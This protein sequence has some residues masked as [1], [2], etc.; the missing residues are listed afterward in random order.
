MRNYLRDYVLV[1]GD[2]RSR[3]PY[4]AALMVLSA[5]L[6]F[7]GL[8]LIA[9]MIAALFGGRTNPVESWWPGAAIAAP[10][11]FFALGSAVFLA[12]LAKGVAAYKMQRAII[13]FSEAHRRDL[14][15][16]LM[17][18]YLAQPHEFHLKRNS[19]TLVNTIVQA[20]YYYSGATLGGSMRMLADALVL[21]AILILLI[22]TDALAVMLLAGLCAL[23]FVFYNLA[24]RRRAADAGRQVLGASSGIVGAVN[25]GIGSY[26][27]SK[28]LGVED[29][30]SGSVHEQGRRLAEASAEMAAIATLPRYMI[31]SS[32]VLF[33]VVF[34]V[35]SLAAGRQP[36]LIVPALA[37]F[38]ACGL[39]IMPAI[40]SLFNG[41][42]AL[43]FSRESLR[44]IADDLRSVSLIEAQA[45]AK[46]SAPRAAAR[47]E[48]L[49]LREVSYTYPGSDLAALSS[50]SLTVR[51]GQAIGIA[52]KSGAGKSTLAD[53]ILGLLRPQAG[54]VLVDG[55]ELWADRGKWFRMVAYIPQTVFLLD[56]T[57]RRNVALGIPDDDIDE[58]RVEQ[59]LDSAQLKEVAASLPH[60]LDTVLGERG[61]R[62]SGGERQRVAL[63]R[64]FYHNRSVIVMD[65]ATS[66]LDSA[67]EKEVVDAIRGLKGKKT[68]IIIAH[69]TST[70]ESC[71]FICRFEAGA[72]VSKE[73]ANA[74]LGSDRIPLRIGS[75]AP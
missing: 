48:S 32:M 34:G 54:C 50:V 37:L 26:K 25:Q 41:V 71:D 67:T 20:T 4:I 74:A 42:Q 1:L 51:N 57:L 38:A 19:A 23:V 44:V 17:R 36:E 45:V 43:R 14:M 30:F 2:A 33:L 62:L 15:V 22:A 68:L 69:R 52:G 18:S 60:G 16:R 63:A 47:F 3:L 10:W 61:V 75:S 8:G 70:L 64:A 59:A 28:V 56:D 66:A 40:T 49:E 9:P 35:G 5:L 65:E 13:S 21:G 72:L 73:P 27:E 55:E 39:R 53:I 58:E 46:D 12:F 11:L 31:E 6:D 29:Y 24:F 7:A